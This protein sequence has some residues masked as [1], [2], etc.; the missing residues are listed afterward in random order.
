MY[1][2]WN[3]ILRIS[4]IFQGSRA[5]HKKPPPP[6]GVLLVFFKNRIFQG[7]GAGNPSILGTASGGV[8]KHANMPRQEEIPLNIAFGAGQLR[9]LQQALLILANL[10]N[11]G[12]LENLAD[13]ENLG[14]PDFGN[15]SFGT[16]SSPRTSLGEKEH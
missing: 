5:S 15:L 10:G 6:G 9:I 8:L 1:L 12:N 16:D 3:N 11:P 14:N 7:P 4:S 2:K 13:L